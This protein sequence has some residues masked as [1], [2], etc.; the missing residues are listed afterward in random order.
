MAPIFT[1]IIDPYRKFMN[2]HVINIIQKHYPILADSV[3]FEFPSFKAKYES[4]NARYFY[5]EDNE[6][7][8]HKIEEL[9]FTPHFLL[10][11]DLNEAIDEDTWS[12]IFTWIKKIFEDITDEELE[13]KIKQIL[14]AYE[15]QEPRPQIYKSIDP[16][17][18]PDY[19]S[20]RYMED[21]SRNLAIC[22]VTKPFTDLPYTTVIRNYSQR[23]L[24]PFF[25]SLFVCS[26]WGV[27]NHDI[28]FL[29]KLWEHLS[30]NEKYGDLDLENRLKEDIAKCKPD[31][32]GGAESEPEVYRLSIE[33]LW[34]KWSNK[35][36]NDQ[37]E[38]DPKRIK[39]LF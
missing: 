17:P 2:A 31:Y 13:K 11:F 35:R 19:Y 4:S 34:A 10:S 5:Y 8:M 22:E 23:T 25:T 24:L 9:H 18:L 29:Y 12:T 14:T 16:P 28:V 6:W 21:D 3:N 1:A 26:S 37:I 15:K 39:T 30:F 27:A 7:S 20:F 33:E 38:L 32:P 36:N